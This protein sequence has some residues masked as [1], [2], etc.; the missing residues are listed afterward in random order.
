MA[1]V[2]AGQLSA[3]TQSLLEGTQLSGTAVTISNTKA[4]TGN[5]SFRGPASGAIGIALTNPVKAARVAA[6][7]NHNTGPSTSYSQ[8]LRLLCGCLKLP[9]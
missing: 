3:E 5:Y 1:W 6:F 9:G 4:N 8:I 7:Q 2:R